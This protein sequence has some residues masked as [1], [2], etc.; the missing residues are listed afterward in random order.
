MLTRKILLTFLIFLI[1]FGLL[2]PIQIVY[3]TAS[4]QIADFLCERGIYYYNNDNYVEALDEFK[5][6]LLANPESKIAREYI[7]IIEGEEIPQIGA[8]VKN[9]SKK[10]TVVDL[11][12]D[13]FEKSKK[14]GP[15]NILSPKPVILKGNKKLVVIPPVKSIEAA[16]KKLTPIAVVDIDQNEENKDFIDVTTNVDER[17]ILKGLHIARFLD[18]QPGIL[19]ISRSSD[20][21]LLAQGQE[22][23]MTYVYVWDDQGRKMLKF[24]V[25]P[26]RFEEEILQGSQEREREANLPESF[27][28]SY[29]IESDSFMTGR[30]IGDQKRQSQSLAYSSS[31]IGETPFGMFDSA[32]QASRTNLGQYM[33]SNIRL[34]LT[35]AHYDQFRDI[36]IRGFDFTPVVSEFGF[37][38]TDLRGV[39]VEAPMLEKRFHYMAF[40]G[41]IPTGDF[42]FLS[43]ASGL[44]QTKR[45][46]L[47]GV[48]V[49]YNLGTIANFKGF[50]AHSYGPER[51]QPVLTSDTGGLGMAYHLGHLDVGSEVVSDTRHLSYAA[52]SSLT[53]SKLRIGLSAME[54]NK[55]FASLFGGLPASGS[56]SG[57]LTINY[58]PAQDLTITNS[59]SG[60]HDRVFFNP[61][62]PNRPNYNSDTRVDWVL[63]SQTELE[64]GY[65]FDDQRGSSTPGV[66]ETKEVTFRKKLFFLRQLNCFLT[67]QNRHSKSLT[68]PAQDFNNNRIL[69]GLSFRVIDDLYAYYHKEFNY[70]RGTF[71]NE[72]AFPTAQEYGLNYYK[73]IF[74]SPFYLNSR[75]FYHDEEH[76]ESVLSF[77]S[78]EDRLE[79]E[80]ELTFKPNPDTE[81]FAKIRV[82]N[83]WAEKDTVTKHFDID[84]SWGLRFL[85]D[86]GLRWQSVGGF[87][88][89]VFYDLNANG[90]KEPNEKGVKGILIKGPGG[91]TAVTDARGY[92]KISH[93]V[94]REAFLEMDL[95]NIPQGYSPTTSTRREVDIVHAKVKRIDFGITTRS[96]ISGLI[97]YDKNGNGKYDAGDEPLKNIMVILDKKQKSISTPLG[98]YMFRELVPGE[99]TLALDLKSIPIKF[100]PKV[101]IVKAVQVNE[102]AAFLYNIPMEL[103]KKASVSVK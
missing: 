80:C 48:A 44:S 94:G 100:I 86:T 6:A 59:F 37:P 31:I 47:E 16:S 99:H 65:S 63:D 93:V 89:Y 14:T 41:A 52:N 15:K 43:S 39:M 35:Q 70:L 84:L 2:L 69:T 24:S 19:K 81:V 34:G 54:N 10:L 13:E 72:V 102:G 74:N 3:A 26:R 95:T 33:I 75:I 96:E 98:E 11:A 38:S 18:T 25:G 60:S 51:V 4:P 45:A 87:D 17:L 58:R 30:G 27:K 29:S 42:S 77:L 82:D 23:G 76:T 62:R 46:W 88:G 1:S 91:K 36:T 103:Q 68:S 66:T 67:Y 79:G 5:K 28:V 56:T 40:W 32:V 61:D 53:F 21:E 49:D 7:L 90:K 8:P 97:F 20:N 83:I 101:P 71:T 12:L 57:T 55:D 50:L 78:G 73:K 85:W 92:Y 9:I 22:I 64:T